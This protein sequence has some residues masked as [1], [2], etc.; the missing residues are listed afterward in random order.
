MTDATL[1]VFR[2]IA[3]EMG[4]RA[5]GGWQWIGRHMSQRH[6][7]ITRERAEAL[8]SVYGGKAEAMPVTDEFAAACE[9]GR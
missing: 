4:I 8:A 9:R 1:N 3:A 5:D 7:G 2:T 6:F